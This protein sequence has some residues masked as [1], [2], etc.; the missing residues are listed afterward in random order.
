[1]LSENRYWINTFINPFNLDDL[2]PIPGK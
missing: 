2:K 1:M